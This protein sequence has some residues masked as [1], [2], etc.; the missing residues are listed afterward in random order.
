MKYKSFWCSETWFPKPGPSAEAANDLY[1]EAEGKAEE[2]KERG[3]KAMDEEAARH[4]SDFIASTDRVRRTTDRRGSSCDAGSPS[5]FTT[6]EG[7]SSCG[8]GSSDA[9]TEHE[10][11]TVLADSDDIDAAQG[12]LDNEKEGLSMLTE[13]AQNTDLARNKGSKPQLSDKQRD[14]RE[15]VFGVRKP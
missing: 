9:H 3:L 4:Q 11:S 13:F 5:E 14:C 15:R 8:D 12:L 1:R 6:D 7:N 2:A 10:E